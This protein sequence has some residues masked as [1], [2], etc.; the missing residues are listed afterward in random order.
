MNFEC[1]IANTF[2]YVISVGVTSKDY[3]KI[4]H[5]KTTKYSVK[6]SVKSDDLIDLL[7][8]DETGNKKYCPDPI[9]LPYSYPLVGCK[10][11]QVYLNCGLYFEAKGTFELS[12]TL[13]YSSTSVE[14]YYFSS[15]NN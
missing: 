2:D 13:P 7:T 10:F 12:A 6:T 14:E 8:T 9:W 3:I 5:T 1:K 11:L 15:D 4:T